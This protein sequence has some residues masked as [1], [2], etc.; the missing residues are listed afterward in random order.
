M[1]ANSLFK[2]SFWLGIISLALL[3]GTNAT[4]IRAGANW[5]SSPFQKGD[6]ARTSL[7]G[8]AC[9]TATGHCLAV[10]DEKRYAEFFEIVG[11]T[12]VPAEVIRLLPDAI[13]GV[14]MDEID[15]EAAAYANGYFY[16]TGSHGAARKTGAIRPS[17]FFVFRFKVGANA[18]PPF[19][20][21]EDQLG[22]GPAPE[23]ER[24]AKLRDILRASPELGRFA[25]Q[26]LS[27][28]GVSIEGMSV[29]GS[30]LMFGFR[31]PTLTAATHEV[32][33]LSVNL[34]A[35]FGD[36]PAEVKVFQL[37]V[38]GPLGIR[39]IAKVAGG[40]LLLLGPSNQ[41][42]EPASL[43][44]WDGENGQPRNFGV[45]PGLTP[46]S[47]AETVLLLSESEQAYHV[48]VILDGVENGDPHDFW[49]SK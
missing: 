21:T 9:V 30:T 14:T 40:Y 24:S 47:K 6:A 16:V 12:I 49:I 33:V 36:A 11:N 28:N 8:A 39:D 48:L 20:F 29:D 15:A 45:V 18:R 43:W 22:N 10:N 41:E 38:D 4:E 31:S 35:V 32:A 26:P 13:G 44:F 1:P 27:A 34:D 46:G 25:E 3:P 7:S 17:E 42:A 23:I 37:A 5:T 19:P 2:R